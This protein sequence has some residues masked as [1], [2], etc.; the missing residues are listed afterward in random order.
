[1]DIKGTF[2]CPNCG[3]IG[4][5]RIDTMTTEWSNVSCDCQHCGYSL[6]GEMDAK[7]IDERI[8]VIPDDQII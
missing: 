8:P 6:S 4:G 7:N 2:N 5:F 1:M 3:K